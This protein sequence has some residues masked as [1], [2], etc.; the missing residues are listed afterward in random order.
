MDSQ[1]SA[2]SGPL[3]RPDGPAGH[4]IT[5]TPIDFSQT[6][7]AEDYSG[8]FAVILDNLL[9][10][11]ECEALLASAGDDWQALQKGDGFR[12]CQRILCSSPEWAEALHRRI[13]AQLPDEVK[14]LRKGSRLAEAVAGPSNL[15]ANMGSRKT[16][17]RLRGANDRLSFL[18]YRPGHFFK[19]HCDALYSREGSPDEKSFLTCQIYLS[20]A[21]DGADG[22]TSGGG[23]TRFWASEGRRKKKNIADASE[24]EDEKR[25]IPHVDVKPKVGRALVFQ[26]RMLWH[27]GQEVTNGEKYTVRLD[28]MFERHF[29]KY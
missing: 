6:P 16:V 21:P 12:K 18:R 3:L 22:D 29:E 26:Q 8:Y 7:L 25:N 10:P 14:A 28:L 23:E 20:D 17:W 1:V 5:A 4:P 2:A 27:A 13:S 9:T 15:K 19:A 11:T 24:P